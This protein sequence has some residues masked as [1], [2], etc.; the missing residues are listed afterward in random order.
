[1]VANTVLPSRKTIFGG[2]AFGRFLSA[3]LVVG[4]FADLVFTALFGLIFLSKSSHPPL[5]TWLIAQVGITIVL[6]AVSVIGIVQTLISERDRAGHIRAD[7]ASCITHLAKSLADAIDF[8]IVDSTKAIAFSEQ[9]YATI[10]NRKREILKLARSFR[11]VTESEPEREQEYEH[12]ERGTGRT[13]FDIL[14]GCSHKHLS[15]PIT[16]RGRLRRSPAASVTGTYVICLDCG[17]E[18]PYDWQQMRVL[19]EREITDRSGAQ[20]PATS[21]SS[22]N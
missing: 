3:F 18:F 12:S 13:V 11:L 2:S 20:H 19:N 17:H 5:D 6:V 4:F 8:A 21:P 22:V 9:E 16:V 1:M 15:F 14:F 10:S 7:L